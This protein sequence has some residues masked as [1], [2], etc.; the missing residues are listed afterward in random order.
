M[1]IARKQCSGQYAEIVLVEYPGCP[2]FEV[3]AYRLDGGF[4]LYA[5]DNA[6]EAEAVYL[7]ASRIL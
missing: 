2:R 7:E 3:E 1:P 5:T 6:R 4:I